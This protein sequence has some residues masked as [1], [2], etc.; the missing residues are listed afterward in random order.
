MSHLESSRPSPS[1][2]LPCQPRGQ[3]SLFGRRR[4]SRN[5][6]A[7]GGEGRGR[8]L[9]EAL[10][11]VLRRQL[12]AQWVRIRAQLGGQP[13]PGGCSPRSSRVSCEYRCP[14]GA[15]GSAGSSRLAWCWARCCR[16]STG[17]PSAAASASGS[18]RR[19]SIARAAHCPGCSTRTTV[20]AM[21][22]RRSSEA[23]RRCAIF[24]NASNA[25]RP[26]ISRSSSR[27][28]AG[29]ARSWSRGRFTT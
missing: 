23:A 13:R 11:G 22:R 6:E 1:R 16:R 25:W 15:K 27:A 20:S 10:E 28:R 5:V 9:S 2:V 8:P 24:A 3:S 7:V 17:G 21:A 18:W 26:P 14:R 4:P 12:G 29:A 19:S